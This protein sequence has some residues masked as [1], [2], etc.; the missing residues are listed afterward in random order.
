[1]SWRT[2]VPSSMLIGELVAWVLVV[3]GIS[4]YNLLELL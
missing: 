1:M 3:V 2:D 4:I